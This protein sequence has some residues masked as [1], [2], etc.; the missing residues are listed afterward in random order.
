MNLLE[1]ARRSGGPY[2][3]R[4]A[5]A[6]LQHTFRKLRPGHNIP[7]H[8]HEMYSPFFIVGSG[9]AGTTLLRRILQ[10]SDEVHI[11][12]ETWAFKKTY[13]RFIQYRS[14]LPWDELVAALVFIYTT[15]S[16]FS[17]EFW[18][19][20]FNITKEITNMTKGDRSLSNIIDTIN[21]SHG[22]FRSATFSRW[23]DKTPLNSF[24]MDEIVGVFP[25]ARFIH[26]V[27]DPVDVVRSYLK[28]DEAAPEVT[29]LESA[30]KR[31][32]NAVLSVMKFRRKGGRVMDVYYED[33]VS[34]PASEMKKICNFLELKYKNIL[35]SS[36]DKDN[37]LKDI[38]SS[39]HHENVLDSI[40]ED[41]IGK[42]RR[43]LNKCDLKILDDIIKDI[44]EEIGYESLV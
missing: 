10:T 14:T 30:A 29:D 4:K 35:I 18:S 21:R 31:W 39:R 8:R 9:R 2:L 5:K 3:Y 33:F 43:E 34:D 25:D 19:E 20:G 28:H 6:R 13:S 36:Y 26:M 16:D 27:R 11:P 42:G 41:H 38:K 24:C 12:P 17:S 22:Y 32:R 40:S 15:Q 1:L 7:L 37:E 44:C 23:G